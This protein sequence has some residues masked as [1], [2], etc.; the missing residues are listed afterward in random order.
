MV[1]S[2]T[3]KAWKEQ[4]GRVIVEGFASG[5]LVIG[6]NTG[7]IP[8][9]LPKEAIVE[10]DNTE[11]L[12]RKIANVIANVNLREKILSKEQQ[13]LQRYTNKTIA[14]HSIQIYKSLIN[15]KH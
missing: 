12:S 11:E 2:R 14:D 8:H 7:S 1:P 5:C 13:T 3:T 6:T 4:F 9:L 15:E 10:E